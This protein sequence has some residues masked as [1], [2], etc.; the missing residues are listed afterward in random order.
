MKKWGVY[1]LQCRDKTLYCGI[2]NNIDRRLE[3]HN[4]GKGAKYTRGR[5]P[6]RLV[7]YRNSMTRSEALKVECEIKG[8]LP[9]KKRKLIGRV[10]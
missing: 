8:M 10:L 2:T 3:A 5:R 9:E 6:L 1:L 7:Y 4:K